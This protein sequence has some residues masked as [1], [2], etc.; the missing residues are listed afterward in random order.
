M[1]S[2]KKSLEIAIADK[3]QWFG[4]FIKANIQ[5]ISE[6]YSYMCRETKLTER[7]KK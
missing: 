3:N 5:V 4:C 6:K 1:L 7:R 2:F